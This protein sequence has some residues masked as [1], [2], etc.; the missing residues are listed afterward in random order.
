[1]SGKEVHG[2]GLGLGS[3]EPGGPGGQEEG[4]GKRLY[5]LGR[6]ENPYRV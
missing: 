2:L 3:G 1:M 5:V 6:A 4:S